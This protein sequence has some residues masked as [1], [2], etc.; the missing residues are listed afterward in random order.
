MSEQPAV[1][2]IIPVYNA[3]DTLDR[4]LRSVV[5]SSLGGIEVVCIND[6]S[7][8]RSG[9]I[10]STWAQKDARIKVFTQKNTG[11]SSARNQGLLHARGEYLTFVDADDEITDT[12][13]QALLLTART[14]DAD[15]VVCGQQ[16]YS[17]RGEFSTLSLP[18]RHMPGLTPAELATLSPSV[19]SHLYT[20][21]VL[22]NPEGMAQFP[23]GVRYGED[24]A[25]HYALFPYCRN[26]VQST[27]TG[28]II[29]YTEGSSN[30]RAA[31]VVFDMVKATAWL[32]EQYRLAGSPE[33]CRECLVR[34]ANHAIRRMHSLG[35]HSNQSKAAAEMS[36]VLR[37][38]GIS[39]SDLDCLKSKDK[40]VLSHILRGGNGLNASYYIKK[41]KKWLQGRR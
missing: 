28:Y 40:A 22:R 32:A 5:A 1:S 10:L 33:G 31:T 39:S 16:Q 15:V 34:Y 19:C 21:R 14:Y 13:L 18:F 41:V 12:Y 9:D 23:L 35:V 26:V 6:G 29:Y 7:T 36:E 30:S 11:V 8:D 3:A 37:Q 24:T 20:T 17:A 38:A 2:V 27:E 4:C 25:F